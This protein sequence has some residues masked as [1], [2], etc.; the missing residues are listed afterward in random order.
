MGR[1]NIFKRTIRN[2]SLHHSINDDDVR[3]IS[4]P[5]KKILAVKNTMFPQGNRR[6]YLWNSPDGK[7][8]NQFDHVL[9]D[10]RW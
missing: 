9:I 7:T 4:L 3:I 2:K 5:Y 1:D 10:R 6:R 8:Q